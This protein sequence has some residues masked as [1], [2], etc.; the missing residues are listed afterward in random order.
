ME[1]PESATLGFASGGK[2]GGN[3]HTRWVA[4]G[5]GFR[6]TR[7]VTRGAQGTAGWGGCGDEGGLEKHRQRGPGWDL[8]TGR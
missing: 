1:A 6:G 7:A 4:G 2:K 5:K 3:F 8:S